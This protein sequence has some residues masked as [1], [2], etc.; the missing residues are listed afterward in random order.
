MAET[1]VFVAKYSTGRCGECQERI[2][3]GDECCYVDDEICHAECAE[4]A[5]EPWNA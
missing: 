2:N 1:G 3:E 4:E 5:E